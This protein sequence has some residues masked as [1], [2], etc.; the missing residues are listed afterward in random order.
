MDPRHENY[1]VP[2][3]NEIADTSLNPE[4]PNYNVDADIA[5]RCA[6]VRRG[7][8]SVCRYEQAA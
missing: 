1:S 8:D 6:D 3:Q 7:V 2:R 5:R 4:A